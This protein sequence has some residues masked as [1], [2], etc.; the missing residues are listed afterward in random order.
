MSSLFVL[1]I[2]LFTLLRCHPS[3]MSPFK[4]QG[5]NQA[6]L[7]ALSLARTLYRSFRYKDSLTSSF[8]WM[9]EYER[10]MIQ[11]STVKVQ[12]SADAVDFL[13]SNVVLQKG[14]CTRGAAAAAIAAVAKV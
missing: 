9:E 13:H 12:A 3:P 7:D 6:M 10:E 2:L 1:T 5:A 8:S 11:R 4:G 14:N